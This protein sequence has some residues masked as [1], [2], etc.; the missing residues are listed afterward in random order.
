M[1][2]EVSE[3]NACLDQWLNRDLICFPDG[4]VS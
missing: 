4:Q 2:G 1:V 3:R